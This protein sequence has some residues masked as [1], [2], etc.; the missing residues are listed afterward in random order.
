MSTYKYAAIDPMSL[1]LSDR[2]Y[3]IWVELHHPHEPA[4][5]KVAE[6]VK[7]LS[8]EEKKFALARAKTLAA[9]SKAVEESLSK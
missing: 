9:Y 4:L 7:T 5:S 1:F 8:V 3:L 2:A 6:V